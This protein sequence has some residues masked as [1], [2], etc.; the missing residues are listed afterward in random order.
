EKKNPIFRGILTTQKLH[1]QKPPK[2]PQSQQ[3]RLRGKVSIFFS[4]LLKIERFILFIVHKYSLFLERKFLWINTICIS[5]LEFPQF[6]IKYHCAES[7]K[8]Y[9]NKFNK[10]RPP[11]KGA[12]LENG[13]Q[14]H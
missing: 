5:N 6:C 2:N 9:I 3:P 7:G 1:E 13:A 4:Q 14:N 8:L 10:P 12:V 11:K